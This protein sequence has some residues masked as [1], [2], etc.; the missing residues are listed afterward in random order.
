MLQAAA[1]RRNRLRM[2]TL[3]MKTLVLSAVATVVLIAAYVVFLEYE[4]NKMGKYYAELRATQPSLYLSKLARLHGF[5]AYLNEFAALEHYDQPRREVPPFLLGRWTLS[6]EEKPV[7]D[8]YIPDA[9]LDGAEIEDG[10]IRMFG[11]YKG[12]YEVKYQMVGPKTEALLA[13]GDVILI[14]VRA[15][16][17]HLHH[18]E[19]A[20]PGQPRSLY[21]YICK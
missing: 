21:G 18:I 13:N 4:D 2:K 20:V 19:L 9:C 12:D 6:A 3:R 8:N 7:G 1:L 11:A 10:M 15:F 16:G 5:D 14:T 17:S